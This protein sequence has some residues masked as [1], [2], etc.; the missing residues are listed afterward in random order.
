LVK[1][2]KSAEKKTKRRVEERTVVL[3]N[4]KFHAEKKREKYVVITGKIVTK[5]RIIKVHVL[6][7]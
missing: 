6:T 4:K 7:I 5:M 3:E 2:E 1:V